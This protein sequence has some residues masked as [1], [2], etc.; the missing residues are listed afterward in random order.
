MKAQLTT[1]AHSLPLRNYL[2]CP[3]P[4]FI[5]ELTGQFQ[6][7]SLGNISLG[8]LVTLSLEITHVTANEPSQHVHNYHQVQLP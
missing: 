4:G 2:Q 1:H 5:I 6:G 8:R 3:A 7:Q